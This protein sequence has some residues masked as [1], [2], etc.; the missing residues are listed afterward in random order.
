MFSRTEKDEVSAL[1]VASG[2]EPA[3]ILAFTEVESAGRSFWTVN[4]K[5]CPAIRPEGHY[6][7]RLLAAKSKALLTR[8][9]NLRIASPKS[10]GVKVPKQ[11]ADVY[12]LFNQMTEIDRECAL[13]S[14]SM[15]VGQVMGEH[16]KRLG[17][18]SVEAMWDRA[19]GS[20]KGQVDIMLRFIKTDAHIVGAIQ[21]EDWD[22]VFR[23]YN[24]PGYKKNRYA[25]KFAAALARFRGDGRG[26]AYPTP[27]AID[28]DRIKALGY[29]KVED[30]QKQCD[31]KPDGDIGPMTSE[32]ITEIEDA[33][34]KPATN[35]TVTALG[36]GGGI[37]ATLMSMQ[38][39]ITELM[40]IF[41]IFR[42]IGTYGPL[43]A[44]AVAGSAIVGGIVYAVY[45]FRHQ[46]VLA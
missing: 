6:F 42:E 34:K 22:E 13:K 28:R 23:R 20:L 21:S 11:Y 41:D 16:Y 30:F 35:G 25:K 1:A 8:A 33:R 4:G 17:F 46:D 18:S 32:A 29:D 15:G 24:G 45:Q 40:P 43:V 39:S 26:S 5:K 19:C 36:T 27:N 14:I 38:T 12:S 9:V 44:A 7:Y 37:V 10:G 3:V 31:L 2:F